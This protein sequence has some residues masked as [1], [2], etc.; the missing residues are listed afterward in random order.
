MSQSENLSAIPLT[1]I[2]GFLGA[3][4]TTLLNRILNGDHGLRLAVL[5]NDFGSVN[6]DTHLLGNQ[7]DIDL[8]DLPNGC[9]CCT[10]ARGLVNAV[11]QVVE[12]VPPPDHIIIEASGVSSP[13]VVESLLDVPELSD[14]IKIDS[15][16]TLADAANVRKLAGA[17]MFAENQIASADIVIINKV[18]L[19]D[20]AELA[21]VTAW[22]TEAAPDARVIKTEYAQLPLNLIMN[23][24]SQE[25]RA[26]LPH[27]ETHDHAHDHGQI[28]QSWTFT[29]GALLSEECVRTVVANLPRS[30]Y[31]AKGIL[32]L[33]T[34]PSRRFVLQVVGKRLSLEVDRERGRQ[35]PA[36]QLVFIGDRG[37]FDPDELE[38]N[39]KRCLIT[40]G[41]AGQDGTTRV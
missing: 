35:E 20:E 30:I 18:D 38:T 19:V 31:R 23:A 2:G 22:I 37:T 15:I 39:L 5:V 10:L 41:R 17:F 3:G 13:D 9:I 21:A 25:T 40:Q 26:Y 8:V 7:G 11:G 29:T 27:S 36:T 33:D 32:N 24:G 6:I 34:D 12:A 4:K 1:I 16:V 28:F 14:Q